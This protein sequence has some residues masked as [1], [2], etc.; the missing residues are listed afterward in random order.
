MRDVVPESELAYILETRAAMNGL[1][2]TARELGF[3]AP[4]ISD[5]I[6]QSRGISP[7]LGIAL[8]YERMPIIKPTILWK[9]RKR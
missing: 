6:K 5:V 7:R 9:R 8:G 4:Y 3:S 1:R 2:A